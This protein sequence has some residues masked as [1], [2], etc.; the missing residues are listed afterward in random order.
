[1][2]FPDV[3]GESFQTAFA[4]LLGA[5][6]PLA[7]HLAEDQRT[8]LQDAIGILEQQIDAVS[9]QLYEDVQRLKQLAVQHGW[10]IEADDP[11]QRPVA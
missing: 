9:T 6:K 5:L 10:Q 3:H 7:M 8:E 1:M 2:P 11:S 4:R